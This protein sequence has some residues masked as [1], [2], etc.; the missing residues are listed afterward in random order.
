L[1]SDEELTYHI[2]ACAQNS[3]ESQKIIYN[4]FYGY[5]MAVCDRYT[6]NQD[7]AMEILNDSFL[8]IFKQIHRYKPA[9]SDVTSS[10]KGWVRKIVI[11]T[12]IDYFRKNY[13]HRSTVDLDSVMYQVPSHEEDVVDKLNYDTIIQALRDLSPGYRAVFNLFVIEGMSHEMIAKKLDITVGSS[14][15]NL[16]KARKQLQRILYEQNILSLKMAR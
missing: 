11:Y 9:Y 15:S 12:A 1:L 14:K 16:S 4:S 5:A 2:E 6:S 10:F 8:K 7:D 13:K 3:R